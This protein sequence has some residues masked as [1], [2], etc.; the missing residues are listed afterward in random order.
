MDTTNIEDKTGMRILETLYTAVLRTG[1]LKRFNDYIG[2]ELRR[3]STHRLNE[4]I[5]E[6][7][8]WI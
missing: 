4:I 7:I 1:L 8:D 3:I 5:K 6:K 2:G